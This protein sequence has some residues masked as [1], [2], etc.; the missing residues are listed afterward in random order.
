MPEDIVSQVAQLEAEEH[1]RL[2]EARQ[3]EAA[4]AEAKAKV[5]FE[6]KAPIA[7]QVSHSPEPSDEE[8]EPEEPLSA[9]AEL[10]LARVR[11]ELDAERGLATK[12]KADDAKPAKANKKPRVVHEMA[13]MDED[14]QREMASEMAAVA[15]AE[16]GDEM[17]SLTV[18]PPAPEQ[19]L[20]NEESRALFMVRLTNDTFV[21][22]LVAIPVAYQRGRRTGHASRKGHFTLCSLGFGITKIC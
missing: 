13:D 21:G 4:E 15:A 16:E 8:D 14:W 10:E 17:A 2:E 19:D 12:R 6:A 22:M 9:E 20:S 18:A 7:T 3:K 11:A 1:R 5:E